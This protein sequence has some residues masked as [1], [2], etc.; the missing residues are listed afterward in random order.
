MSNITFIGTGKQRTVMVEPVNGLHGSAT[1]TLHVVDASL[2]EGTTSFKVSVG[3]AKPVV[4]QPGALQVDEDDVLLH[5]VTGTDSDQ[6]PLTFPLL[7]RL[8]TALL[9]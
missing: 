4:T 1:I 5:T 3:N 7:N 9:P 6:D 8:S 2:A